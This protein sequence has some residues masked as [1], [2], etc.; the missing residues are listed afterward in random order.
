MASGEDC[1]R[2]V[3]TRRKKDIEEYIDYIGGDKQSIVYK[4]GSYLSE[5]DKFDPKFFR[6]TPK[7]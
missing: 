5:I 6:I 2:E 1:I 3:S 7:K 4:E